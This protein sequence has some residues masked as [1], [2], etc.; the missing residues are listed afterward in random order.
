MCVEYSLRT[1]VYGIA[2]WQKN[3]WLLKGTGKLEK[4]LESGEPQCS[5]RGTGEACYC[6]A[7]GMKG[8]EGE[9]LGY[10]NKCS[11][12]AIPIRSQIAVSAVSLPGH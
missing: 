6:Q 7:H 9:A 3:K 8:S 11:L 12:V 4:D 10:G 5:F 2:C 1:K